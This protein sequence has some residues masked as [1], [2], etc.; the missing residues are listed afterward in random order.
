[1]S[2]TAITYFYD[3]DVIFSRVNLPHMFSP[4]NAPAGCGTIQAEVYFSEKY[5]PLR[6]DPSELIEPVIRDLRRC[7]FI[8]ETDSILL[9]DT[10]INRFANVIYDLDRRAALATPFTGFSTT[11]VSITAD[12]T[13]I[14]ITPGPIKHSSVASRPRKRSSTRF[15]S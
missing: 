6:V 13:G 12:A 3:D 11:S 2:E 15:A 10:A 14:G 8:R 5:K 4:H 1:M 9:K 7:G